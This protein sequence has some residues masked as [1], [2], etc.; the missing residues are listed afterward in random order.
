MFECCQKAASLA[1]PLGDLPICVSCHRIPCLRL[2]QNCGQKRHAFCNA[3]HDQSSKR[4][5][6][7]FSKSV[8]ASQER[9]GLFSSSRSSS[10]SSSR[11]DTGARPPRTQRQTAWPGR[12]QQMTER[13]RD[14]FRRMERMTEMKN[15]D[16]TA[17]FGMVGRAA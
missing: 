5:G 13:P 14:R 12:V 10:C 3:K 9:R 8:Q 4:A 7:I 6:K 2:E 17:N 11:K 15:L 16:R 1:E